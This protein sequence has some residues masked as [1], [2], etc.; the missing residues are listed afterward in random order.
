MVRPGRRGRN[1]PVAFLLPGFLTVTDTPDQ[2]RP[3]GASPRDRA[4]GSGEAAPQ[5]GA[6]GERAADGRLAAPRPADPDWPAIR[7]DYEADD[8][9]IVEICARHGV[10]LSALY[11]RRRKQQWAPRQP[12]T[13]D[14]R[15]EII[16]RLFRLLD[17]HLQLMEADMGKSESKTGEKEARVLSSLAR[18]LDKLIEMD[19]GERKRR[20]IASR[21]SDMAALRRELA[22]RIV[23]LSKR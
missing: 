17:R 6:T 11:A 4:S 3:G 23:K 20:P 22:E 1:G 18:T 14:E 15:A 8:L 19:A 2:T 21:D 5:P 13:Y 10:A 16:T 7:A 9:T 12:P